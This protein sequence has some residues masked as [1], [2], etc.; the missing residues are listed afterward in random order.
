M[1]N[2]IVSSIR[3]ECFPRLTWFRIICHDL[4]PELKEHILAYTVVY[5]SSHERDWILGETLKRNIP[6]DFKLFNWTLHLFRKKPSL[7]VE[8]F[9]K[10]CV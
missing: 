5:V 10:K 2:S 9:Y 7:K 1:K 4:P 6:E 8:G 3:M